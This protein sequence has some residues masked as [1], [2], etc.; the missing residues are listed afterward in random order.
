MICK[1]VAH[2]EDEEG[3]SLFGWFSGKR[4]K[5][6][7][8]A[9]IRRPKKLYACDI[10]W[11]HEIGEA[12][13]LEGTMPLYSSLEILKKKHPC[14]KECGVVELELTKVRTVSEPKERE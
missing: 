13:D 9:P 3:C 5:E 12:S 10:D 1:K 8:E 4:A 14:W 11:R 6:S 7:V 2:W